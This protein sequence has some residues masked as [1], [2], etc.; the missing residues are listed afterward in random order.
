MTRTEEID[1]FFA[2]FEDQDV[3]FPGVNDHKDVPVLVYRWCRTKAV[4]DCPVET[5]VEF[6]LKSMKT[7]GLKRVVMHGNHLRG[8]TETGQ[9]VKMTIPRIGKHSMY[10]LMTAGMPGTRS[11]AKA[12]NARL[13]QSIEKLVASANVNVPAI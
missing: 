7:I 2:L 3:E 5:L 13:A 6:G 10:L 4:A 1:G 11:E 9:R 12:V 8:D